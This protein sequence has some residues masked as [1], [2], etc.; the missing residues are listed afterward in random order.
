MCRSAA[1]LA[2]LLLIAIAVRTFFF[3]LVAADAVQ[4]HPAACSAH[5]RDVLLAF[6]QGIN[7]TYDVLASWQ[8]EGLLH[9]CCR[10]TGVACSNVTGHVVE[11]DLSHTYLVGQISPSLLYL[12]H[13]EYLDLSYTFLQGPADGRV[14][15]FLGSLNN[16]R[17]LD[18]TGMPFSGAVP[19][20]LGNLSKLEYLS[21]SSSPDSSDTTTMDSVYSTDISWLTRLPLLV[22]L[23]MSSVNLTKVD[24]WPLVMNMIP[25]LE[26]LYLPGCSLPGANYS[27][28]HLN[29]TNL[30]YLELSGNYFDHPVATCWF[31]NLTSIQHLGL[32][33]TYLHGPFPDE[34]A[35][36]KALQVGY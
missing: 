26:A 5:E 33:N 14:P 19:P 16:L 4:L 13:L 24:D 22:H 31:W 25:S 36:M 7:D 8:E 3:F 30:H 35:S 1:Q 2:L 9:D 11:L 27:L 21:L 23:N 17:H 6:K 20:Q 18:L 34:L 15:E 12:E 10:W 29:L 28:T 32:Y